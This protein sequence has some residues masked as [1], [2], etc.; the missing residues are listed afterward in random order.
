MALFFW[1]IILLVVIVVW[2]L[3]MYWLINKFYKMLKPKIDRATE[4]KEKL[5]FLEERVKLL[6]GKS[7]NK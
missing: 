6:E 5:D 3:I 7:D 4:L 1:I 2:V